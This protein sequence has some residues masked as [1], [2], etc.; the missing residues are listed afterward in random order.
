VTS[1]E[2]SSVVP[3]PAAVVSKRARAVVGDLPESSP[4][5]EFQPAARVTLGRLIARCNRVPPDAN[6][7]GSL[8]RLTPDVVR[9]DES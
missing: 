8:G 9:D 5:I 3:L 4:D 6:L 2:L 7:P 1:S